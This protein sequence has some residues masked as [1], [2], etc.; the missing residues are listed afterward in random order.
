MEQQLHK[1]ALAGRARPHAFSDDAGTL[2]QSTS[3]RGGTRMEHSKYSLDDGYNIVC[4]A[5]IGNAPRSQLAR[6]REEGDPMME[7]LDAG[8]GQSR[9]GFIASLVEDL[10][11][12]GS[13]FLADLVECAKLGP[14][15]GLGPIV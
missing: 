7:R 8:L 14:K 15:F 12:A 10:G 11:H 5:E 13:D 3:C 9:S 1:E 2:V 4:M 6:I